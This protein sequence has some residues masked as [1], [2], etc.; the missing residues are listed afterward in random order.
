MGIDSVNYLEAIISDQDGRN[1]ANHGIVLDGFDLK[2]AGGAQVLC[3][4]LLCWPISITGDSGK[5]CLMPGD[6]LR[7]NST[8]RGY[9]HRGLDAIVAIRACYWKSWRLV[10]TRLRKL[11]ELGISRDEVLN[12]SYTRKSPWRMSASRAIQMAMPIEWLT[13]RGLLSLGDLWNQFA[14]KR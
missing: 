4:V 9:I 6:R 1:G 12:H 3:T 8:A 14:P 13:T 11:R 5:R 10:K 2:I 7:P